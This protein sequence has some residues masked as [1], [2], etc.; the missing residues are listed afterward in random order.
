[1][2]AVYRYT[3]STLTWIQP[4]AQTL[5]IAQEACWLVTAPG[6]EKGAGGLKR[7]RIAPFVQWHQ[8][9]TA[10]TSMRLALSSVRIGVHPNPANVQ[11]GGMARQC[12]AA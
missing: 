1:M 10:P 11:D 12:A 8:V 9:C 2:A 7:K 5:A 3:H 6:A 4:E